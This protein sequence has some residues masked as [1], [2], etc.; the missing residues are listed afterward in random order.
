MVKS[1]PKRRSTS[2]LSII[3]SVQN[4]LT[5]LLQFVKVVIIVSVF[6]IGRLDFYIN[7]NIEFDYEDITLSFG[8][9]KDSYL[10][11]RIV[12]MNFS[13]QPEEEPPI[14]L[15][16]TVVSLF[17]NETIDT[18]TDSTPEF[19]NYT[20]PEI[21]AEAT[22][23][24][25]RLKVSYSAYFIYFVIDLNNNI[26]IFYTLERRHF[27]MLFAFQLMDVV[28]MLICYTINFYCCLIES[29]LFKASVIVFV[30]LFVFIDFIS[31]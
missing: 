13:D 11:N 19:E 4:F 20:M 31:Y 27:K 29:L 2:L 28:W 17:D 25:D 16:T 15:E 10:I 6:I 24:I 12:E 14:E 30:A 26:I 22:P 8:T 23:L 9:Y 21:Y 5:L 1:V 3:H 18:D 7:E